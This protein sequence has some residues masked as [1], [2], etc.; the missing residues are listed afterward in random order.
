[1][2]SAKTVP[3][4]YCVQPAAAAGQVSKI[5]SNL[6]FGSDAVAFEERNGIGGRRESERGKREVET[7]SS[8]LATKKW[9]HV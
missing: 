3:K 8:Y 2:I 6:P 7:L 5:I 1:M 9:Q 4:L